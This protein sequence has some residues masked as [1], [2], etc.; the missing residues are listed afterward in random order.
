[1][2]EKRKVLSHHEFY[3]LCG[4]M[5]SNAESLLSRRPTFNAAAREAQA[6]LGFRVKDDHILKAQES[7]NVHWNSPSHTG[8]QG[9]GNTRIVPMIEEV[10][11]RV[12]QLEHD[13]GCCLA[14]LTR[15]C[16]ELCVKP[17][18]QPPAKLPDAKPQP[19]AKLP[20]ANR[21]ATSHQ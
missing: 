11:D 12:G 3:K 18:P 16:D 2:T 15:L 6:D 9:G 10:A 7:T 1:M 8:G 14:L 4:W 13:M 21:I 19:P 20:D 17:K 5:T